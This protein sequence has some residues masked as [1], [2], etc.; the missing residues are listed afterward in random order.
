MTGSM[1]GFVGGRNSMPQWVLNKD[2]CSVNT[3][4]TNVQHP[5]GQST[6]DRHGLRKMF[7]FV[8]YSYV[9]TPSRGANEHS[10]NAP[11]I[12]YYLGVM[13]FS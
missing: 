2:G 10:V 3:S 13:L 8:I 1:P 11:K 12:L 9:A 4:Y 5:G 6:A 7:K